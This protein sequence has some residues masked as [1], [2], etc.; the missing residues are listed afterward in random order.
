MPHPLSPRAQLTT[1]SSSA[2]GDPVSGSLVTSGPLL[3]PSGWD[4]LP[5]GPRV[6][7]LS[8][9][10]FLSALPTPLTA[11]QYSEWV[12]SSQPAPGVNIGERVGG[13]RGRGG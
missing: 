2:F 3:L 8:L 4:S 12:S 10:N 13:G 6:I 11:E 7:S 9:N 1:P 5:V